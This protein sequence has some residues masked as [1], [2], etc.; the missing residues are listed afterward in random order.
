MPNPN[1]PGPN[2]N[3]VIDTDPQII[4]VPMD[5]TEFGGRTSAIPK[6]I[7]NQMTLQHVKS[8]G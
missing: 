7:Q 8:Q 4:K 2:M 6:N 3:R 5:H 1:F